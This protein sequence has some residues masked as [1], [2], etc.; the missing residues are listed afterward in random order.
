MAG[1]FLNQ[2][3]AEFRLGG[4]EQHAVVRAARAGEARAHF[5]EIKC[6]PVGEDRVGR[7]VFAEQP[8]RL[9]VGLDQLNLMLGAAGQAQIGERLR[10]DGEEA[11]GRAVLRRHIA[12]GCAI[13][14]G[15]TGEAVAKELDEFVDHALAPQHL[16]DSQDEI[17][18]RRAGRQCAGQA[19]TDN[20]GNQ[21]RTGTAEHRDFGLDTADAPADDAQA[22]DHRGVGIGAEDAIGISLTGG[23][24][25][26]DR[27]EILDI[28]LMDDAGIGR[29]D[30][31]IGEGALAPAQEL[32]AFLDCARIQAR[33]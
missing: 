32:I 3:L 6:E 15:Q 24:D 29:N 16:G 20:F 5:G 30:A 9:A 17:G 12:D 21:Q 4:A 25:E 26:D 19:E 1:D 2:L 23:R 11:D 31:E 22:V 28:D 8:L 33:H 27:R 18:S 14:H 7:A 10:I 13:G